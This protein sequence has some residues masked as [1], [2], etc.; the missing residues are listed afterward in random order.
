M[1]C[2]APIQRVVYLGHVF[3]LLFFGSP[4]AWF[5]TLFDVFAG[6]DPD[7]EEQVEFGVFRKWVTWQPA[8]RKQ[9]SFVTKC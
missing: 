9:S 6:I 8:G 2:S 3:A 1:V 5:P 4:L 7:L